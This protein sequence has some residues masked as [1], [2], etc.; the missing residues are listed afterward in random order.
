MKWSSRSGFT[1]IE[2]LVV[3]AIIAILAGMLLPSLAKAKARGQ[4]QH[5]MNNLRQIGVF[6][7]YFTDDNDEYFPGHRN[8]GAGMDNSDAN[9]SLTNWWG[10]TVVGKESGRSNLFR[11]AS[12][13][14]GWRVDRGV[15]WRWRF[16]CHEVGYGYNGYF[17]GRHP[18]DS[19]ELQTLTVAGIT[20]K[21]N[22]RFKRSGIR[23]P[24]DSLLIGDKQ[25]YNGSGPDG[26]VWGSSL[27]WPTSSMNAAGSSVFEGIDTR[28]HLG[29]S[30]VV[31]NDSHVEVRP[32]KKINPQADPVG[33]SAQGLI[34]AKYW[35]P[36][37][38]G[39][40]L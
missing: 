30:A 31:F 19:P 33:G 7:H 20:F 21:S 26:V 29:G 22:S 40:K 12:I 23:R 24:T 2:L 37:Q 34:N 4:R 18:Y 10:T 16:D 13:G 9:I 3:I 38:A 35:D 15:R 8:Q 27:W 36:D 1:L 32:D 6:F 25:P 17:L 39:G 14:G 11:C 28:R 5:C